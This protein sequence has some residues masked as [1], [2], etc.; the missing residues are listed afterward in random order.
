MGFKKNWDVADIASQI[1]SLA[2]EC[3]SVYNDGFTSFE[4][5]KDLYQLKLIVDNALSNAPD[6]G[7]LEQEWLTEQEQKRIIKILKS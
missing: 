2:R 1:H 3:S 6:F 7:E 5:K 4:C